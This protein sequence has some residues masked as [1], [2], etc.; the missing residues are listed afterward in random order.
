VFGTTL[1][2]VPATV[3]YLHAEPERVERWR[4]K[5]GSSEDAVH[6]GVVW[7]GNP[8]HG[9]DRWRSFPLA[10]LAPLAAVPGVQLVSLQKGAGVEQLPDPPRTR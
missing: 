8:K 6:V 9:W 5:L 4:Q 10:A 2:S 7:Q 3:P 1:A